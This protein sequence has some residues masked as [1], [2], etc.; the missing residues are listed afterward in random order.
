[1]EANDEWQLQHRY[2]SVEALAEIS[3]SDSTE[4]YSLAPPAAAP[5]LTTRAA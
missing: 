3:A 2:L 5:I 1:M 4:K